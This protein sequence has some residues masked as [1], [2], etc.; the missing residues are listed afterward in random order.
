M[1]QPCI[2]GTR[3][4]SV[5]GDPG[6]GHGTLFGPTS[7]KAASLSCRCSRVWIVAHLAG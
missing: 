1:L 3:T 5:P 4:K 2:L 6:L 7:P